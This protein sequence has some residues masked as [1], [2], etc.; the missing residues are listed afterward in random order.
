MQIFEK[1][2]INLVDETNKKIEDFYFQMHI[3]N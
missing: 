3:I 2:F 1:L